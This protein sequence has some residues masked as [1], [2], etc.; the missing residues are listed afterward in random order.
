MKKIIL[1]CLGIFLFGCTAKPEFE[2]SD[3]VH[4]HPLTKYD[5]VIDEYLLEHPEASMQGEIM[6]IVLRLL[7]FQRLMIT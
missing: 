1:L 6:I 3:E 7:I 4:F 2:V 5:Y